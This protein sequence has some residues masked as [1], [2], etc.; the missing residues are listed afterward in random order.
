MLAS[1]PQLQYLLIIFAGGVHRQQLDV[2][3]YLKGRTHGRL[4]MTA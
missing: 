1:F 4:G 2:I 3:G